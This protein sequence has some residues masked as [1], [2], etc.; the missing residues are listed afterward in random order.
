MK[1]LRVPKTDA[2]VTKSMLVSH[3]AL[4]Y[5]TKA[6][7]DESYVYFPIKEGAAV[8]DLDYPLI[9][10]DGLKKQPQTNLKEALAKKLSPEEQ[11]SLKTAYDL[12]GDIAIIE[13]DA[14]LQKKATLIAQTLL[15][16]FP[17]IKAVYQKGKHEGPYR[18]Q[19][20]KHLAGEKRKETIHKENGVLLKLNVE[21]VYFSP[22]L[23]TERKRIAEQVEPGER[24]LV[25]FSG[26]APYPCVIAK[27]AKP[28]EVIGIELNPQGHQFG[29]ENVSLNKLQH[30]H[31]IQGDVRDKAPL[32]E[33]CFDRIVMPLP[34][35]AET[36]LD[37]ALPKIVQGG[38]IHLYQFVKE[39]MLHSRGEELKQA[40]K[41]EGFDASLLSAELCGQHA[42]GTFR[43]CYDIQIV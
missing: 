1:F 15:T 20:L 14:K 5:A 43:V 32:L 17:N 28:S 13:V 16:L 33:G 3:G 4:D 26:C 27:L 21:T 23:A 42:P 25:M 12:I 24:V 37:V 8:D 30:V 39:E 10:R 9:E 38:I 19:T 22:R 34:K 18:T 36:Y 29:L 7:S 2:E 6:Q 11:A 40:I 31:L 41:K 35:A